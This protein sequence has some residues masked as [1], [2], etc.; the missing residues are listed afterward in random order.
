MKNTLREIKID[1]KKDKII[2]G[3]FGK[4]HGNKGNIYVQKFFIK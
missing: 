3:R 1:S 4:I 2:V